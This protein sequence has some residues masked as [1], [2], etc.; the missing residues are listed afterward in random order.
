MVM[1]WF[2]TEF[3]G[4]PDIVRCRMINAKT[5]Q[6]LFASSLQDYYC[7]IPHLLL[8]PRSLQKG[9]QG[10]DKAVFPARS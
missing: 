6:I 4:N 10:G 7:P 3:M 9:I 8:V 2:F 1:L 5:W